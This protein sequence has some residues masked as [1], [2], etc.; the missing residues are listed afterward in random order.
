MM[1]FVELP[2][3][4]RATPS[5]RGKVLVDVVDRCGGHLKVAWRRAN[6][7]P[8]SAVPGRALRPG[9]GVAGR[10]HSDI[11][12][13]QV[14]HC[15]R[16]RFVA[17]PIQ[18]EVVRTRYFAMPAAWPAAERETTGANEIEQEGACRGRCAQ[19]LDNVDRVV[20]SDHR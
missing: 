10:V 9:L 15:R 20:G 12:E 2:A 3:G 17:D 16:N 11:R 1:V 19:P 5:R 8:R 4:P 6:D 14:S 13:N 18:E 7:P